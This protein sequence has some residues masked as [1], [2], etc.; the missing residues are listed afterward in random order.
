[1]SNRLTMLDLA[2]KHGT[3]PVVGLIEEVQQSAPEIATLGARLIPGTEYSALLR[4]ALPGTGFRNANEGHT[5]TKSTFDRKVVQCFI[6][7]GVLEVDR[8]VANADPDGPEAVQAIEAAGMLENAFQQIG[9]QLYYGI[10]NDAKGFPG[11]LA[12]YDTTYEV[13]ATGST[14]STGSSVWA[15]RL[16]PRDGVQFVLGRNTPLDMGDWMEAIATLADGK[17]L[18]VYQNHLTTWVGVQAL[19]KYSAGRIKNLTAQTDKGLTDSL[20]AQ[21]LA[22]FP[23]GHKPDVLFM[24]RR[25]ALQLQL[26]RTVGIQIG[27]GQKAIGVEQLIGPTPTEAQGL[28]IVVTD[29]ILNTEAIV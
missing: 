13:D 20:I 14:P 19:S 3:D 12:M 7:G 29:S 25:S 27:S 8:A 9:S 21:L 16:N 10:T 24:N 17:K 1:M 4:T 6:H 26:S 22:K 11:L 5:S 2:K 28:P 23:V 18:P 15:V